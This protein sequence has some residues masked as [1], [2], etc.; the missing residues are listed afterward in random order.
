MYSSV[1]FPGPTSYRV[2]VS[3]WDSSQNFFVEKSDLEWSEDAGK[4]LL[5]SHS[6]RDRALLFV[7]LI[8]TTSIEASHPVPYQVEPLGTAPG[9]QYGFR[10]HPILPKMTGNSSRAA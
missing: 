2:E 7:R 3:G 10:L 9:G 1:R 5:L 6:L 4:H 8:H